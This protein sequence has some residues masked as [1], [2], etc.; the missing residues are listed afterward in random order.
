MQQLVVGGY[1][2]SP[3]AV[4]IFNQSFIFIQAINNAD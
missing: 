4:A 1:Q 2:R 3:L